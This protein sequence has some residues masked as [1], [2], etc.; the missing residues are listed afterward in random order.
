M[1][2]PQNVALVIL[3]PPVKIVPARLTLRPRCRA[4]VV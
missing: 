2:T 3:T 1:Y 4:V